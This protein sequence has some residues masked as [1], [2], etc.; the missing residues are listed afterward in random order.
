M[1]LNDYLDKHKN[2]N[3]LETSFV[4]NIFYKDYGEKGLDL[5]H[6]QIKIDRED[7]SGRNFVIDFVLETNF[8]IYA[9]ETHGLQSHDQS[10]KFVNKERF[11]DLI[12][13]NNLLREK[14]DIYIELTRE[15]IMTKPHEAIWEL[16]KHFKAD[17]FLTELYLNRGEKEILPNP[18]QSEALISLNETRAN[19]NTSGLVVLATG[20]GKTFLSG[21]DMLQTKSKKILFIAHVAEILKK[22][23]NDFED[24]MPSRIDEMGIFMSGIKNNHKDII[25]STIQSLSKKKNLELFPKNYFDYIVIDE[26]H[27][28]AASTYQKVLNYFNPK[29][30]LGLT[31]T[32]FRSDDKDI[33]SSFSNNLIY[34]FEQEEA[35]KQ[36]YLSNIE[37][38]GYIDNIDY[39]NIRWNGSKYDIDDL[40]KNLMVEKR[41]KAILSKFNKEASNKKTIGFCSCQ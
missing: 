21:F 13:K 17:K 12:I 16:R 3:A 34:K 28:S 26:A 37:Y 22:T 31:A 39:S 7:G 4:K 1:K 10:G 14:Y 6:P 25:F 9:I 32:P 8:R 18:I 27:H 29:F 19:G 30:L 24:L 2:L 35:V 15:Q 20:L 23:K 41:D 33:L 11:D 40:N 5:L 38:K 36:G